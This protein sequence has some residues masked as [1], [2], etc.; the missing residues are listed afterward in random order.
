M[1]RFHLRQAI[2][3]LSLLCCTAGAIAQID[4]AGLNG[5]VTDASGS[6]I[7]GARI[8]VEQR[9]TGLHR[10]TTTSSTG[11]YSIVDLP[12]GQYRISCSATGFQDRVI[13]ALE[14]TVGRTRTLNIVLPV[15][16]A[17]QR[18]YVSGLASQI[19]ETSAT[20]GSSTEPTQVKEL[21]LNGR[22]WSTLTA[23]APGAVD[24]GGSNQRSIRFAGR[25]LDDN[26]FTFDGIDA[27]NIVNQAQQPFVRLAIPLDAVEEFHIAVML[28]TADNGSTPG[29]QVAVAS[30]SGSNQFH[31]SLFE[32]LRNSI[33]DARQP[34]DTLDPQKPPFRLNQ[35]GGGFG[36]PMYRDHSF[37]F[38]NYEGLRQT[39]GQTLVGYVPSNA[40]RSQAST[41]P[42]L[43]A[44]INAFPIGSLPVSGNS[45]ISEFVGFGHQLDHENSAMLRLDQHFSA[46]DSAYLRFNFDAA[47]SAVP[48]VE[49]GSYINNTQQIAS[50]PVNGE[51]EY[52]HVFSPH[53]V[54]ELKFGFNRGNVYTTNLSGLNTPY[55]IS[56][57][58]YTPLLNNEFK[59]GVGNSYSY[60]DNLTLVHGAHTLKLGVETRRI[61]LNQG[62]TANG[63]VT[64]SSITNFLNNSVSSATYA[65]PLPVNGL[66]KTELYSYAQ[67]EWKL[68]PN[69]TLNL[70]VRYTF[71]NI[72]HEVFGRAIPFDF[73]TCGPQGFCPA[74]ASFGT[75]NTLDVD[76]RVS[77]IWSPGVF[78]GNT[79][80]RAGGGLYHGDGQLDDQ[81]LP[82][83]NEVAQYSL[84]AASTPTLSYPVTPFFNGPGTVSARDDDRNRKDSYA[85]QWGL[86]V[87]QNLGHNFVNTLSYVGSKGT[88]LLTTS[89]VNLINPL[90]STR[91][92]SGFGQVQ[93]RG[94]INNSSYHGLVESLQRSFTHGLLISANYTW[95]H[96]IDQDSPGGGDADYPQNPACLPCE[97]TSGDYDVRHV[98]NTNL[99]YDFPFGPGQRYLANANTPLQQFGA[100]IL[101][102]WSISPILT[103]RTGLPVNV[104]EDRSSSSVATGYATNQRPNIKPGVPL[105]PPGGRSV[106]SWINPAAFILVTGTGYG[107]APRN[108]A[109]GPGLWQEDFVLARQIPLHKQF[110]M[111]FRSE[112]FNIFNRAQYGLPLADFSTTTFGQIISTVNTG[113]VG[114]GTPRQVQLAL[115][116]EF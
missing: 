112:F 108:I 15:A 87:Q 58:G 83:S 16:G 13:D 11:T 100:A 61:Q 22:N 99:V 109:R 71:F 105:T 82:I 85:S 96:Q 28:F 114:T 73:A 7:A 60:I 19:D 37:F 33:F 68:Q 12:I 79:I 70:G 26:N 20:L 81:N 78:H 3:L 107:N 5:T 36:G 110:Q 8:V 44:I 94:N 38:I 27:T 90:T 46:V 40:V 75:T 54:D 25:G 30:K 66:R 77:V 103:A 55:T 42:S 43:V 113:P 51:I 98:L 86:S 50:R 56:I 18:I 92:Y 80:V 52:L 34:D 48:I 116:L 101:S 97:R 104:T 91:P 106:T 65:S 72:F 21:P 14:Q 39:L 35:F 57:S 64:F 115:R 69:L 2:F 76:P 24:T 47:V 84:S 49:G 4:L 93:W 41:N 63:T 1:C 89:Y 59:T 53:I 23:L 102:R 31:G 10:E 74:G 45:Q 32:Y 88:Y 6:R 29:G 95:S 67:D 9:S 111:Q 62:N 17:T